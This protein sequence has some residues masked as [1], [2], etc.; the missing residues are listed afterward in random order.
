MELDHHIEQYFQRRYT[1]DEI[2]AVLAEVHG[3]V[4]S[5]R[6]L[7]RILR[8][9]RLW[10][11]KGK[12]DVAEV[13]AFIKAQL[14]TS[15]QCHGYR[16]MYQKC[17]INGI[18]TDRETVRVLL[19]L[20]DSEGV[21]LRSR[22]RL[23]RRVYHSRG[24]NYVWH[25]DGY[26]KLKPYG[27]CISG[28]IDGFSRRLIWLE[29]YKTNNDPNVIAGYFMDAVLIAQGC[30][31]RL[32]VDLGTENV[33]LAEMQRF[34]HFSEGQLEIEHVTFGPSTGNQR[35][36]RWWL[37]LRS[38]CA[39]FWM[40]F[41]DKLKSDGYFADTFLDKSLVQF[42][43]LSTIQAE[44]EE[45]AFIWNEHRM[46]RVHNS[47]SPHGRPSI[48]HAVPQ[49]YGATDYLYRPS[50]EKIE[51]CLGECVYKDFPC[52]EDVFHICVGLM[53]EHGLELTND[54]YKTVD[55]YVRLRQLIN[56]EL[57]QP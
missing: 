18:I 27:I 20:L 38:Q 41:F 33:R 1:N 16:W 6:T 15:G 31:E 13:A 29:A 5:K 25:I 43:F 7:E 57:L 47:R 48:I 14:Q 36:E 22:N 19:R 21:D 56:N 11:R 42:C 23:R 35:I 45:V 46:R 39:Q 51:A 2:L 55:L 49:L 32:R 30:P 52:D 24:P 44:L 53:S 40:D 10:R 12:T 50:L 17:W 54:V 34:M 4:L 28:C 26:D 3:V 9:K 8:E 37:T